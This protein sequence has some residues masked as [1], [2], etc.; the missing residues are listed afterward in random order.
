MSS[1]SLR[2]LVPPLV[3]AM[4]VLVFW[5]LLAR[6][7]LA[8]QGLLPTP[9]AV[10]KALQTELASGRIARDLVASLF[11]VT[12][13]FLLALV[14]GV[15]LGLLLGLSPRFRRAVFPYVNFLRNLS[16]LAWLPFAVLWFG[17]GDAPAIFLIFL[18]SL[19]SFGLGALAAVMRVPT[20]YF[21]VARESGFSQ[22]EVVTQLVLPCVTPDLL[23]TA[24]LTAGVAWMVVVPAEMLAG[25]EGLGFSIMDARN[26]LR[27]DL[28][29]SYM[30]II[31]FIGMGIDLVLGRLTRIS[32][33]RWAYGPR[34]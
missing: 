29:V 6:G 22:R 20:S 24:R 23:T 28:L 15:P 17:I 11:R 21:R 31:G 1:V 19:P 30:V 7:D 3:V 14:T 13:G 12:F 8:A 34:A 27:I 32:A 25:R 33:L 10:W 9:Q 5:L 4:V 2:T 16:P 18:A 26:G